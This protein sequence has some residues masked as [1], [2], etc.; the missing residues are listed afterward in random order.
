MSDKKRYSIKK[1]LF[2][3]LWL[4]VGVGT[5]VLLVAAM[6]NKDQKKCKGIAIKISG[7]ENNDGPKFVDEEDI[8]NTV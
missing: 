8:L 1:I 4:T 2:A 5:T 7:I 3:M 6:H